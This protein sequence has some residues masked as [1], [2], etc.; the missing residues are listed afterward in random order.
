MRRKGLIIT[1]ADIA[2]LNLGVDYISIIRIGLFSCI[3]FIEFQVLIYLTYI[4]FCYMYIN[5]QKATLTQ[6]LTQYLTTTK[7]VLGC[8]EYLT[9]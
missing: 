3:K 7:F 2:E 4:D 1:A 8:N 5:P 9:N 6:Y